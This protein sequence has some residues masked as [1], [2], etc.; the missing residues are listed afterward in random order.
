MK[1]SIRTIVSRG[2]VYICGLMEMF[3]KVSFDRI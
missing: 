2:M 3:T 1:E